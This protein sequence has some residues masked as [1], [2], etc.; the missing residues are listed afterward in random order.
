[1]GPPGT[2]KSLISRRV[3][4]AFQAP[5]YFEYLMNCFSTPEE[6]FGPVSIKALKEDIYTRKT[7]H[8][9]PTAEFAFFDEI[10]KA[11]PVISHAVT[12]MAVEVE[13]FEKT[14]LLIISDFIIGNIPAE[15]LAEMTAQRKADNRF[16]SLAIGAKYLY[17]RHKTLFDRE[18]AFD[19]VGSKVY[20]VTV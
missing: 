2:A 13:A 1:M 17:N 20:Q 10:W 14:D 9:L 7:R 11:S 19:P 3:A 4:S 16:Y 18:W 15:I 8:Y 6:I 5:A 12:M